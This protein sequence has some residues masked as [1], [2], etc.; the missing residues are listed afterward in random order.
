[1]LL[2]LAFIIGFLIFQIILIGLHKKGVSFNKRTLLALVVG[3]GY[4]LMI[5]QFMSAIAPG[6]STFLLEMACFFGSAYLALLKMLVIPLVL[7]SIVYSILR[8]GDINGALLSRLATGSVGMLLGMTALASSIGLGVGVLF[9][10][11]QGMSLPE[12]AMQPQHQHAT[13]VNTLVGMIPSNPVKIMTQENTVA[14]VIFAVFIGVAT[15]LVHRQDH[16]LSN[17][18]K[19]FMESAFYITKKM[20]V[21]VIA[22]TPYGVLGLMTK[23]A[24]HHGLSSLEG[25]ADFIGAMYVAIAL[26]IVMHIVFLS[27]L[28]RHNPLNY[29]KHAY[30]ALLVAFTTRSSFGTLP[31]TE[32]TLTQKLKMPQM[33]GSFVPSLGATIGMNACAGVFP[34]MLVVMCMH[35]LHMPIGFETVL[36]VMGVNMLA[37][38][39]VSGIP[40]T[41]FIAAGVT[42]TTL[43]LPYAVVGIVQG[44]DPIIDMGRTATNVNGTMTTALTVNRFLPPDFQQ[45]AE[46]SSEAEAPY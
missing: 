31:V 24:S 5:Q 7:T 45:E 21:L 35:I 27:L 2:G 19:K 33:V 44:I 26:V 29:F 6:W 10:V 16:Q 40:G 1:M 42:L 23:M 22:L 11:G 3:L 25:L 28:A 17:T 39:G 43:G 9:H 4:G 36:M 15:V 20:A 41:A 37:S 32:E 14:L 18:F 38:L 46:Q 13:F 8:L 30:Q 34:A 12:Q